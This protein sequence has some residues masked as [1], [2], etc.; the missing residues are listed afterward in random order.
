[1]AVTKFEKPMGTEIQ[2]LSEQ[3]ANKTGSCTSSYGNISYVRTGNVVML[4]INVSGASGGLSNWTTIST[5][6]PKIAS[7]TVFCGIN[8]AGREFCSFYVANKTIQ[9]YKSEN[10]NCSITYITDE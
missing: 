1:M 4:N 2:S 6:V 5:D 3:M 9:I 7:A 8:S 10:A